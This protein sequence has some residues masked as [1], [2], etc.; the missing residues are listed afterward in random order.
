MVQSQ[1]EVAPDVGSLLVLE[2][3]A[4]VGAPVT[5]RLEIFHERALEE[6]GVGV[7]HE[8]RSG[9]GDVDD[10]EDRARDAVRGQRGAAGTRFGG[11][12][13]GA[14]RRGPDDVEVARRESAEVVPDG[15]VGENVGLELAVDV[16][17]DDLG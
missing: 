10:A 5:E 3:V 13:L 1:R 16:E 14:R 8:P 6:H 17:G 4:A 12:V 9:F 15:D 11:R 2:S 7:L